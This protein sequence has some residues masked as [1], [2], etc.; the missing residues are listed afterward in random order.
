MIAKR[1][2]YLIKIREYRQMKQHI[3][4]LEDCT[5]RPNVKCKSYIAVSNRRGL[6]SIVR[7]AG[8]SPVDARS[9]LKKYD[10]EEHGLRFDEAQGAAVLAPTVPSTSKKAL[11]SSR[12]IDLSWSVIEVPEY[13]EIIQETAAAHRNHLEWVKDHIINVI[14]EPCV[15]V[16]EGYPFTQHDLF[17]PLSSKQDMKEYL[18]KNGVPYSRNAH[19]VELH[20]QVKRFT[21]PKLDLLSDL[22]NTHG[23]DVL[24]VPYGLNSLL[25]FEEYWPLVADEKFKLTKMKEA[26]AKIMAA[27]ETMFTADRVMEQVVDKLLTLGKYEREAMPDL[28]DYIDVLKYDSECGYQTMFVD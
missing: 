14:D 1:L 20:D 11:L 8:R 23:H 16:Y 13:P 6:L 10:W 22:I 4:Y 26:E 25:F 12:P 19:R 3:I 18:D 21:K 9:D 27:E 2:R 28:T 24:E 5:H 15:F 17:G 7:K